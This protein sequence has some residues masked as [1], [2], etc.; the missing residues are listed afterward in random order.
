MF[1]GFYGI[2]YIPMMAHEGKL[3]VGILRCAEDCGK[4]MTV[5][6]KMFLKVHF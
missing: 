4:L 6:R 3:Y 1:I 2:F 5:G